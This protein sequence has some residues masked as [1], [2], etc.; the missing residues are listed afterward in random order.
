MKR[1][2]FSYR[3]SRERKEPLFL[4]Q[5]MPLL[6]SQQW[7]FDDVTFVESNT[8]STRKTAIFR[9]IKQNG[10]TCDVISFVGNLIFA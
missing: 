2:D 4:L 8:K 7:P 3:G 5:D 6:T 9:E 10:N 1:D